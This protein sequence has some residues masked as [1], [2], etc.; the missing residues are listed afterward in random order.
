MNA[1][2]VTIALIITAVS[3]LLCP[4]AAAVIK[5]EMPVSKIFG[6]SKAVVVGEVGGVSTEN[7]LVDVSVT[8]VLRGESPGEKLRIQI[9]SPAEV[10]RKIASGQPLLLFV[11][12]ARGGS[13]AAVH[14]DDTW[15]LAKRVA[16]SSPQIWRVVG[17]H[18][19]KATFPGRTV[20][21]LR[22]VREIAAGKGT[23]LDKTE[24]KFFRSGVRKLAKLNVQQARWILA[25]NVDGN[26]RPD[27][28]IG[29]AAGGVRLMLATGDGYKDVTAGWGLGAASGSGY[30]AFSRE[31]G[32][33]S[34][35][36]ILGGTLWI[37]NHTKFVAANGR[38]P[39][40]KENVSLATALTDVNGDGRV[41]ALFLTADGKVHIVEN[42]GSSSGAWRGRPV[43]T[44]W[45]RDKAP[46]AAE[47]GD[48]GD[49]AGPHVLAVRPSGITRYCLDAN[50]GPPADLERL[51]GMNIRRDHERYSN[52]LKNVLAIALDVDGNKRRDLLVVCDIGGMLLIN[53]GFGTFLCDYDAGGELTPHGKT[54][55]KFKITSQTPWTAVDM[56]GDGRDDLLVLTADGILYEVPNGPPAESGKKSPK[57]QVRTDGE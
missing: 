32:S 7:R 18:D 29:T 22:L 2:R 57:R 23:I 27:L 56:H 13:M 53:R 34:A 38:L 12:K 42:P 31:N 19:A 28:L 21:L 8:S 17:K 9:V 30:R 44:L 54:P 40:P 3:G 55:A 15:L 26:R 51:T 5:V 43:K 24:A 49:T 48:W 39:V 20:A 1:R 33:G 35:D 50:G 11:G 36:L 14:L 41:D 4:P 16:N 25:A 6:T 10:I 45:K 37:N 47:F 46:V 52:G